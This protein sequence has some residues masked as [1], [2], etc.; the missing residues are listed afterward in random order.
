VI[1]GTAKSSGLV[2]EDGQTLAQVVTLRD[3]KITEIRDYPGRSEALEA[4]GV[5]E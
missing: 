2:F 5:R 4:A 1:Q 3:G